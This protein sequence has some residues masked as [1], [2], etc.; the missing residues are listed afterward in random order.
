MAEGSCCKNWQNTQPSQEQLIVPEELTT[1]IP[2]KTLVSYPE[3][4]F[5][6][7]A[8]LEWFTE[9]GDPNPHKVLAE[10]KDI[11]FQMKQWTEYPKRGRSQYNQQM[12]DCD[13]ES[14]ELH[15]FIS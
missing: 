1:N 12:S 10:A 4:K 14:T 8:Q 9:G 11:V 5:H 15:I 6:D 7:D 2:H 3:P 13:P